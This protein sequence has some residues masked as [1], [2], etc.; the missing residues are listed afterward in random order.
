M[1]KECFQGKQDVFVTILVHF[2][3]LKLARCTGCVPWRL[4]GE[5]RSDSLSDFCIT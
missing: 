1:V 2:V 3:L 5:T 4:L